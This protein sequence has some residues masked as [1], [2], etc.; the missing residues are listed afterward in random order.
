MNNGY[1]FVRKYLLFLCLLN[2]SLI[3]VLDVNLDDLKIIPD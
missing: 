3:N 2:K 1:L